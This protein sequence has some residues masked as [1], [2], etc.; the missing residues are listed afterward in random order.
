MCAA[1]GVTGMEKDKCMI[2]D[3]DGTI[4]LAFEVMSSER[5]CAEEKTAVF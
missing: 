2:S 3:V 1:G 4:E 5:T